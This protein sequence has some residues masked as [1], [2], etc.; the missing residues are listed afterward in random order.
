MA[1]E[2]GIYCTGALVT[3]YF[4]ARVPNQGLSAMF[5]LCCKA[6]SNAY[7]FTGGYYATALAFIYNYAHLNR[8]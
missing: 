3:T 6:F 4:A 8:P 2:C 5:H 7:M 1:T